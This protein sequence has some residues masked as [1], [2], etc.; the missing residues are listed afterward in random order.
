M[1][2]LS[3]E[4]NLETPTNLGNS[5]VVRVYNSDSSAGTITKKDVAGNTLGTITVPSGEVVYCEKK[6]T[7]TLEGGI[8]LKASQI[9]YSN[10]MYYASSVGGP[11][12]TNPT[13]SSSS[14]AN[15]ATEIE[16]DSNI[17]LN[18]SEPVDAESGNIVIYKESDDSV[19]ETIDVT[20]GQVTG[21]GTNQI[22][23]NP[24]SDLTSNTT[25]Y[26]QIAATAFDDASGNSY[27]G[28]NDKTSLRFST[29]PD[30][31][32]D[33]LV[34]HIDAANT[35][36]Y[37]GSGTT[38]NSL[39]GSIDNSGSNGSFNSNIIHSSVGPGHWTF[40]SG[41]YWGNDNQDST[42]TGIKFDSLSSFTPIGNNDFTFECWFNMS[43]G[44]SSP[45]S[46]SRIDTSGQESIVAAYE[47]TIG[48]II[49]LASSQ[50]YIPGIAMP[51]TTNSFG[52]TPIGTFNGWI[53]MVVSH[54]VSAS[55]VKV[56]I[57]GSLVHTQTNYNSI[58]ST[59]TNDVYKLMIGCWTKTQFNSKII[60]DGDISII[61]LYKGK[62][63]SSSEVTKNYNAEKERF[64]YVKDDLEFHIDPGDTN[65]YSGI[66]T[67]V[68]N[69]IH[70]DSSS[71]YSDIVYSTNNG[72]Y[73]TFGTTTATTGNPT[74]IEF[75]I[76]GSNN[77]LNFGSN[78][79]TIEMWMRP[80]NT[81]IP[82]VYLT[83]RPF[84]Y[85]PIMVFEHHHQLDLT[86]EQIDTN[87]RVNLKTIRSLSPFNT[88][89]LWFNNWVQF[90]GGNAANRWDSNTDWMHYALTSKVNSSGTEAK[91][92]QYKNGW[93]G[94]GVTSTAYRNVVNQLN[95][96]LCIGGDP[97]PFE[98]SPQI[99]NKQMRGDIAIIRIYIGKALTRSEIAMNFAAEKTRYGFN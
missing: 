34:F 94:G 32:T 22:T 30:Y 18:F 44:F 66:G 74:G 12:T 92:T 71:H 16:V 17:V 67:T 14:P 8:T 26:I 53:H 93:T 51:Y 3:A 25:F 56:Y 55:T 73:W 54:D 99:E 88:G 39:V 29:A 36:C 57:N 49:D 70:N 58:Y 89:T 59:D 21:S 61:R 78:D 20:S 52:G 11:D 4:V 28:I 10:M 9:A 48:G 84:T 80:T 47:N 23:I 60:F 79:F 91:R 97:I 82:L 46:L 42:D 43:G 13:L 7:D 15:N 69:L 87:S 72:G 5:T 2:V 35:S 76:G 81:G 85:S 37:S 50:V 33:N 1:K 64:E 75:E 98:T 62:A 95:N 6:Y 41:P 19:I 24:S 68:T 65:S 27:A 31:V 77:Y 90:R 38:V 63:L 86:L 40:S 83:G 45:F 96:I